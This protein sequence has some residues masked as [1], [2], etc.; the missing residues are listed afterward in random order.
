[1]VHPSTPVVFGRKGLPP[2]SGE[3]TMPMQSRGLALP[4]M[5]GAGPNLRAPRQQPVTAEQT[6]TKKKRGALA[7]IFMPVILALK[8]F[9]LGKIGGTAITMVL[10]L[11]IY[12]MRFGW[13]YAAGFITL[14][15]LHE[16]GH[17]L[18]ARRRGLH[19]GTPTF[20]PFVGA[21]IE[22]KEQPMDAETEAH[23][24]LAGPFV[25]T[26]GATACYLLAREVDSPLLLA[27]A[28]GG[29][30]LN[31]F[32][33]IPIAP[34]DGGRIMGVLSPRIWF[35]GVPVMLAL[36]FYRPS[37]LLILIAIMAIP[38]LKRA[39]RY[40]PNAPENIAYY[41]M[42]TAKRL[43]YTGFYLALT[44]YLALMTS[45]VHTDL[46][47][48]LAAATPS[49]P[50]ASAVAAQP[51][52]EG[53]ALPSWVKIY[54]GG[55]ILRN[56]VVTVAG[57]TDR[58]ITFQTSATSE[59]IAAFYAAQAQSEGF[60]QTQTLLGMHRFTQPGT[61]N[62]FSYMIFSWSSGTQVAFQARTTAGH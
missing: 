30:F 6:P 49:L 47:A 20:I 55:K 5:E 46:T 52:P 48:R 42:P 61:G 57:L 13:R 37:P 29:L 51:N 1:M 26:L 54:P 28:Y 10:S 12:T 23:V 44:A 24:A 35:L 40:D 31:F 56:Q 34:L 53:A 41:S 58:R 27:I 36:L 25:G 3:H 9:K 38:S 4:Y 32:N 50:A 59:Q 21:W 14:L 62:M 18:A 16:M 11:V 45:V 33:L 7:A 19:V 22:L 39:W 2:Q 15:F 43:E 8:L 60:T 17:Y